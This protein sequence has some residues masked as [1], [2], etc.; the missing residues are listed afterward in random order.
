MSAGFAPATRRSL[1][2]ILGHRF[3]DAALLRQAVA[4]CSVLRDGRGHG[5]ER[6]EFLGDRVLGMAVAA[7]VYRQYPDEA[8]GALSMRHAELVRKETLAEIAAALGIDGLIAMSAGEE[9]SGARRSPAVLADVM[10]ALIGALFLDGGPEAAFAFVDRHWAERMLSHRSPP[11]DAKTR[12]QEWAL[13]RGRSLPSYAML[14]R[15][16]PAHAPT[17][18]VS[19]A[20]DGLGALTAEGRSRRVAEQEA[21]RRML[22]MAAR[23]EAGP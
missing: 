3:A 23:V 16:G 5:Y 7:A 9:R 21:A 15:T 20:V 1:E 19:V 2:T 13:A 4:H 10:E 14:D 22:D 11:R 12:L 6:L 8:E 18:T 17:I